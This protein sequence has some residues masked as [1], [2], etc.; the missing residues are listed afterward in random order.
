MATPK[1]AKPR[2]AAREG[3]KLTPTQAAVK[4]AILEHGSVRAAAVALDKHP[5]TLSRMLNHRGLVTWWIRYRAEKRRANQKARRQR[6]YKRARDRG[7]IPVARRDLVDAIEAMRA[8]G[9]DVDSFLPKR[10]T[11]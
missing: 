4:A 8:C 7:A 2:G 10:Y 1:K 3:R 9:Y 6:W 5:N 11:P